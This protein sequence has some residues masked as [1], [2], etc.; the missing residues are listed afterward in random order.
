MA[1]NQNEIEL[2]ISRLQ[3]QLKD[4]KAKKKKAENDMD[5]LEDIIAKI[6]IKK[7]EIED[8]LQETVN[9]IEKKLNRINPKSRFRTRYLSKAKSIISNSNSS[10]ALQS[11]RDAERKAINKYQ[12][13]DDQISGY[14]SKISSL[15]NRLYALNQQLTAMK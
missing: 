15:E 10:T 5:E 11:T 6:R 3:K 12:N 4:Y 2:E 7:R 8:G 14:R 1:L 9:N 13:L